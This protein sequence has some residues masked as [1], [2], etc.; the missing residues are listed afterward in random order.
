M[1]LNYIYTLLST[2]TKEYEIKQILGVIMAQ[3]NSLK[4]GLKRFWEK[5]KHAVT[6][7]IEQLHEMETL[8]PL[9]ANKQTNNDRK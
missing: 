3:H 9:N 8:T 5:G 4:A 2:R 1:L 7:D 6:L